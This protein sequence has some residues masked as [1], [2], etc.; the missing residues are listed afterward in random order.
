MMREISHEI[1]SCDF[2]DNANHRS[3]IND[4]EIRAF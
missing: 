4:G 3:V 2:S 1:V